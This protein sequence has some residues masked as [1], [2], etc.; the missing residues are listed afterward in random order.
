MKLNIGEL[1]EENYR[2]VIYSLMILVTI[3]VFVNPLGLPL[4]VEEN[5]DKF[6]QAI[7]ALPPRSIVVI[8]V[9]YGGGAWGEVGSAHKA[10]LKHCREKDLRMVFVATNIEG[11]LM[12][13]KVINEIGG[14]S[15]LGEYGVDWANLGYSPGVE[16]ALAAMAREPDGFHATYE[17]DHYTNRVEDLPIME[18]L[19][20]HRDIDL[21]VD[22]ITG[23]MLP[24]ISQWYVQYNVPIICSAIGANTPETKMYYEAGQVVG[25]LG[26]MRGAA[27]YELLT[28]YFGDALGSVEALSLTHLLVIAVLILGNAQELLKRFG[29]NR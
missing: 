18:D 20:D 13:E 23:S 24:M 12:L 6:Y 7:E 3:F 4:T 8:N 19:W 28:G 14:R 11:P 5:S 27:E 10:L 9:K 29:G 2:Q 22:L 25:Y 1:W 26:S 21:A 16:V 17:L 15:F